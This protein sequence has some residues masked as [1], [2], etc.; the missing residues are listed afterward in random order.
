MHCEQCETL[1]AQFLFDELDDPSKTMVMAHLSSCAACSEKLGDLRVTISLVREG[2]A[3]LPEPKLSEK[4]RAKLLKKLAKPVKPPRTHRAWW[5]HPAFKPTALIAAGLAVSLTITGILLPSLGSARRNAR[6]MQSSTQLRGIVQGYM[7]DAAGNNDTYTMEMSE[8]VEKNYITPEYLIS[9]QDRTTMPENYDKWSRQAQAEWA[10][11]NSSYA[12]IRQGEKVTTDGRV[13]AGFEKPGPGKTG[14]AVAFDD[15]HVEYMQIE[16]AQKLAKAQTGKS[17]EELAIESRSHKPRAFDETRLSTLNAPAAPPIVAGTFGRSAG[18]ENDV[19]RLSIASAT[20]SS[21]SERVGDIGYDDFKKPVAVSAARAYA[22]SRIADADGKSNGRGTLGFNDNHVDFDKPTAAPAEGLFDGGRRANGEGDYGTSRSLATKGIIENARTVGDLIERDG[23]EMTK[24]DLNRPWYEHTPSVG[25]G[26]E[27]LDDYLAW[28]GDSDSTVTGRSAWDKIDSRKVTFSTQPADPESMRRHIELN[29]VDAPPAADAL[30]LLD[31]SGSMGEEDEGFDVRRRYREEASEYYKKLDRHDLAPSAGQT[32]NQ[33]APVTFENRD[34]DG[35]PTARDSS[36]IGVAGGAPRSGG[37]VIDLPDV[38]VERTKTTMS[39]TPAPTPPPSARQSSSEPARPLV[40]LPVAPSPV[41]RGGAIAPDPAKSPAKPSNPPAMFSFG[42]PVESDKDGQSTAEKES[43][44]R[45]IADLD[46]KARYGQTEEPM[47]GGGNAAPKPGGQPGAP[48][49]E[50]FIAPNTG[51]G[52]ASAYRTKLAPDAL[53]EDRFGRDRTIRFGAGVTDSGFVGNVDQV[54]RNFDITDGER[55]SE[56]GARTSG[57]R[58]HP[59]APDHFFS[60]AGPDGKWGLAAKDNAP[61]EKDGKLN[62]SLDNLW[63]YDTRPEEEKLAQIEGKKSGETRWD[64]LSN[65]N[66]AFI[67]PPQSGEGQ[68]QAGGKVIALGT[69]SEEGRSTREALLG[70]Q[71]KVLKESENMAFQS[72]Q[73]GKDAELRRSTAKLEQLEATQ[74]LLQ[75]AADLRKEG[76]SER[77]LQ[78]TNQALFLDPG[79]PAAQAM[80]MMVEDS[81]IAVKTKD[82]ASQRALRIARH[83][84]ELIEATIP[85][86]ELITYPSDWPQVTASRGGE[87]LGEAGRGKGVPDFT[88]APEFDLR[89]ALDN[90]AKG[91]PPSQRSRTTLFSDGSEE[92]PGQ[93]STT[94]FSEADAEGETVTRSEIIE[95]LTTLVQ[96]TV[97]TTSEWAA[98]GGEVSSL[99]ELNHNLIIKSTPE[100]HR[101]VQALLAKLRGRPVIEQQAELYNTPIDRKVINKLQNS[102]PVQFENRKLVEVVDYFRNSTGVNFFVN[103]AALEAAGVEQDMLMSMTLK[104]VPAEQALKLVLK[105]AGAAGLEPI[106]YS[107]IDGVVHLSTRRDLQRSTDTEVYNISDLVGGKAA[108]LSEIQKTLTAEKAAQEAEEKAKADAHE[109]ARELEEKRLAEL[110]A[111]DKADSEKR[112]E[113]QRRAEAAKAAEAKRQADAEAA[114][115]SEEELLPAAHF[116][117]MPVNPWTLAEEDHQST[118]ALDVD[119]ASYNLARKY[120]NKGYQPPAGSVRMEEFINAMDYNYPCQ[121]EGV[122]S[123]LIEAGP[124]PFAPAEALATKLV[125]V[126]VRGKVIG[127]DGRKPAHVVLVVD[128]SGSMAKEDRLPLVQQSLKML[129]GELNASDTVALVAFGN[130]AYTLLDPTPASQRDRIIKAID[131]IQPSGQTNLLKGLQAGYQVAAQAHKS[132]ASNKVLLCSDGIATLG[133]SE[134][135]AILQYVDGYRKQGIT[136]TTVGFGAGAYNDDVMENLANKGD[137]TYYFVDSVR[138]ARRVFVDDLTATLA[139]IAKDAKIQVEFNKD[140][141]RRYRLIGYEN[142]AIADKD[143]RNDTID[144]GEV[145]SGQ[146]STALYEVELVG[147]EDGADLGTVFVRYRNT[148]TNEIEEI[149]QRITSSMMKNRSPRSDARFYLAACA[150]E[151]AE[152]LR[153]SEHAKGADWTRMRSLLEQAVSQLPLDEKAAELLELATRAQG[154]P[155][156]P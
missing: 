126:A 78:L 118:F 45:Q 77:A 70:D 15:N 133:E 41:V 150:A 122:F 21:R 104:D 151:F 101:K 37:G 144:A 92:K 27:S 39:R 93:A 134:A 28:R 59:N 69:E 52:P 9:P 156:A 137:G 48:S 34:T 82:D 62:K 75:R 114:R 17:L 23:K 138:E 97:G 1:L 115:R 6:Q 5:A 149:A 64:H 58:E 125:K 13:I 55:K 25:S 51:Y 109:K 24:A 121:S 19:G 61:A 29:L 79:N 35:T 30:A 81:A 40:L 153:E 142:R 123:I 84:A 129:I 18:E 154:L 135:E 148:D 136:C 38:F 65:L 107:V 73:D 124:A 152:I 108:S 71:V 63:S 102:V 76:D 50:L 141:V 10:A 100:N 131:S 67:K 14:V 36:L 139:T 16:E 146:S 12:F 2:V 127:R 31:K 83:Q 111:R 66:G 128:A 74:R 113:A 103:W 22:N 33:P 4:K 89:S 132:G 60:G 8:L 7:N 112:A 96:D 106:G 26:G 145:G 72:V 32:I 42:V 3:A 47:S 90:T 85:Y 80:K 53:Q 120:I 147:Q 88:A 119:T 105:Q 54:Q 11:D 140:R 20:T 91:Q 86:N 68:G 57:G 49:E 98:Y 95:Q 43:I 155:R 117:I 94:L 99:R 46:R 56:S 87:E 116:K 130:E 44:R 110:I 143:F